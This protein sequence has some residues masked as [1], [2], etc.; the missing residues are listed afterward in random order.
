MDALRVL[1]GELDAIN[2]KLPKS[3]RL[4]PIQAG[5]LFDGLVQLDIYFVDP[6]PPEKWRDIIQEMGL[7][8]RSELAEKGAGW[9][10]AID[11]MLQKAV[12]MLKEPHSK[13]YDEAEYRQFLDEINDEVSGIGASVG[14]DPKGLKVLAVFPGSGAEAAG[15]K[16]GDVVVSV[17]GKSLKGLGLDKMIQSL[18]GKPGSVV[19]LRLLREGRAIPPVRVTRG[20]ISTPIAYAKMAGPGVGYVFLSEFNRKADEKVFTLIDRL[21]GQGARSLVLDLRG[22]PGGLVPSVASIASEFLKDG[23]EI[24]EFRHQGLLDNKAVTDGDGRYAGLKLAVLVDEGSASASEIL[25]G[26][27]QDKRGGI[28]IIG[29]RSFG[30]GSEQVVLPQR[31]G[32]GLKVTE[33]RWY[34]P[35]GRNIDANKDPGTG[36][37]IPGTGGIVP[38]LAVEVSP[39]QEG[40]IYDQRFLELLG[41]AVPEPRVPD[42]ALE[43]AVEVLSGASS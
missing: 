40:K 7:V 5:R 29:S 14:P 38:D 15:V 11:L 22:N 32:R 41:R 42:P 33:N 36:M 18:R 9:D 8:A 35:G 13:Y 28:A 17:N 1:Y 4:T 16:D 2:G 26:A 37:E 30:K 34:T 10:D 31:E 19:D 3:S 25:A 21:K 27:I 24:V 6:I 43:K 12:S 23:E 39:E 20:Y